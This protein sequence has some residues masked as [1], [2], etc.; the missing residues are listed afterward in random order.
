MQSTDISGKYEP[1]TENKTRWL[2]PVTC[3]VEA[4]AGAEHA[5]THTRAPKKKRVF[6]LRCKMLREIKRSHW[7]SIRP[8]NYDYLSFPWAL[9]EGENE[10]ERVSF[11]FTSPL[12]ILLP[13]YHS[14]N[15]KPEDSRFIC[16][17]LGLIL[18]RTSDYGPWRDAGVTFR[19]VAF[20]WRWMSPS[21]LFKRNFLSRNRDRAKVHLPPFRMT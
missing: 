4:V 17:R 15:L 21:T 7:P 16:L 20:D 9:C 3:G 5:F 13:K 2:V 1:E 18:W 10:V 19:S 6:N 14:T 11:F 12:H 8:V